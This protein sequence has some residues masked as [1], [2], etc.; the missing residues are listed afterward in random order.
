MSSDE[1]FSDTMYRQHIIAHIYLL[2]TYLRDEMCDDNF[3]LL[4]PTREKLERMSARELLALFDRLCA[5][6][7]TIDAT[8]VDCVRYSLPLY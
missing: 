6:G 7:R 2:Q 8:S 3:C 4:I 1:L 5:V